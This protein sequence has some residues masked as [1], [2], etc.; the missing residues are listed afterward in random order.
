MLFK[1]LSEGKVSL[2]DSIDKYIDLPDKEYYPTIKRI[3]T[4]TSGYNGLY[5]E[6]DMVSSFFK[7][8]NY[9]NGI[10]KVHTIK[11][12]GNINLNNKDYAF[13]YANFGYAVLGAV[14]FEIYGEE[15][16]QLVN[17][18]IKTDLGLYN[19][20]V[21]DGKGDLGRYWAWDENDAY[22]SAG[23][24]TSSIGDMMKYAQI[25]MNNEPAY[26]SGTHDVLAKI[27]ATTPNRAKL[28]VRMDSIGAA[29]IID[30]SNDIIWHSGGTTNYNSYLGFDP[31]RKIAVAVLTNLSP[32]YRIPAAVIGVKLLMD[33]Q[34]K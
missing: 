34:K 7:G 23:A 27:N 21:S 10:S 4:H 2:D 14:L 8:K 1:A 6:A 3:L 24:L 19:T 5:F 17:D 15:Y 11:R 18:Y 12:I 28:N 22:I 13:K 9:F 20:Q 32:N 33:L 29:W 25:Q 30:D 31:N 26:I 16:T